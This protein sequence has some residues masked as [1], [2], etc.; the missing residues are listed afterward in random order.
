MTRSGSLASK[1]AHKQGGGKHPTALGVIE[2]FFDL[3]T[4]GKRLVTAIVY[5]GPTNRN[6]HTDS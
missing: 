3:L 1:L 2:F 6:G 4:N 5:V